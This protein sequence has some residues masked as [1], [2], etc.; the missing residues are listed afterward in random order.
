VSDGVLIRA[1]DCPEV[2]WKNGGGTTRE[3]ASFP[4]GAGMDDFDWRVSAARVDTPGAFSHFPGIDRTIAILSGR[5]QLEVAD[6]D[7]ITLVEGGGAYDFAGDVAAF[8][9]PVTGPVLDLNLMVRRERGVGA[10]YAVRAGLIPAITA[11]TIL[12]ATRDMVLRIGSRAIRMQIHD[13]FRFT[14]TPDEHLIVDAPALAL[15]VALHGTR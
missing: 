11:G 15:S 7:A 13:A 6:R 10:I 2:T 14:A 9:T 12:L 4:A 5:L 3:I 8:G 1:V